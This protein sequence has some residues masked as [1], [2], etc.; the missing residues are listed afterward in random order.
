MAT[1]TLFKASPY[2]EGALKIV[3]GSGYVYARGG[4][5]CGV[6]ATTSFQ[7]LADMYP[8]QRARGS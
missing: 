5:G 8:C 7:K 4:L 2:G 6:G 3:G 1:L